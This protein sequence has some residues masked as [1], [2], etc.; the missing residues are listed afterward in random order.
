MKLIQTQDYLLLIDE[1]AEIKEKDYYSNTLGDTEPL[2]CICNSIGESMDC[3]KLKKDCNKIIAYYP[4]NSE[5]KELDL[6][7]LPNPFEE[8]DV[9]KLSE[10][11]NGYAYYGKP[12]GERYLAF[13]EGFIEGYKSAQAKQFSLEDVVRIVHLW[14][15][16][17]NIHEEDKGS[18]KTIEK[19]I[20]S[21][22][23]QQ[24]PKEFIPEYEYYY[25]IS[26][27][28][29]MDAKFERCSKEQY[30]AI[31]EEIPTC[32]VKVELITITNPEGKQEL[33]GSYKY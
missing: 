6:P 14:D 33:V 8:I 25:H 12:L 2:V 16:H 9:E 21:L 11:A 20:Q 30:D 26:K 18:V 22:S 31:K 27:G 28:F 5:V 19:F 15:N 29:Y 10:K 32:P 24:L 4:L 1:E 13:K 23:I 7:E 17:I 3:N